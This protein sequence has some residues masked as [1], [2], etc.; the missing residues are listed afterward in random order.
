MQARDRLELHSEHAL[1]EQAP[2]E[3]YGGGHIYEASGIAKF[4]SE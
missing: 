1:D 4:P 3:V 2:L